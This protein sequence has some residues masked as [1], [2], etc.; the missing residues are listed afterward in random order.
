MLEI[1]FIRHGESVG[2]WENRFRGRHDFPL[3]ENGLR[4]AEA[5]KEELKSV[6]FE[7][8]YSS[9]LSRA[10][11]TAEIIACGK[12]PVRIH[13][14]FTNISL[15]EWENTPKAQI[16]QQYPDLWQMWITEPEKLRFPGMETLAEVQ[17]RSTHALEQIIAEHRE[18]AIAIV[19]HRAVLKPLFAAMLNIPEPYFWKLHMDTAAYSIAVY[20]KERGFTFMKINENK[21]LAQFVVEDLG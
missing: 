7:V 9:P 6:S 4:Q 3:N 20:R 10:L 21:H 1:Y 14:G 8:I 11:K 19:T 12:I 13:D 17:R 15:G 16:Q 5:L 18:G 2:N